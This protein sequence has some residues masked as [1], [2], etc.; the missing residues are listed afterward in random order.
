MTTMII[1]NK[2]T[3]TK[4]CEK[5]IIDRNEYKTEKDLLELAGDCMNENVYLI[6]V[7]ENGN[8]LFTIRNY[9]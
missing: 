8:E 7:Y 6:R 1:D 5:Y 3:S 2:A 9:R 4:P